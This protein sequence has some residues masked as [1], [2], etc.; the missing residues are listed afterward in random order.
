MMNIKQ[1]R[2]DSFGPYENWMFQSGPNGVQLVYGANESGKTSLLEGM[3]ALLFG[4]KHKKYGYVNG[5][6]ELDKDGIAYHLGRQNKNLDF[7]SPGG[8]NLKDEPNQ[9]WWHG[10]DKKT[11]NRIFGLTLDDLQGVDVLNEVDVRARFFGAEGGE[12]LGNVVKT[13]EM[14]ANDLLV[15]SASGK[16]RINVLI[17]QLQEN[18]A[19]LSA[20]SAHE[21]QYVEL[22]QAL[23]ASEDTEAEIQN[24]IKEWQDYREGVEMVLRAW[25][26]YRR[27]EEA[28]QHMQR[29]T[30]PETL[31]RDAFLGIDEGL[32]EARQ[33]MQMW[34]DK[35][36]A[37]KPENF[38]PNSPFTMYGQDIEDLIQQGAQWEQLRRECEEGDAYIAKVKEQLDFSRGLQSAWRKDESVPTDVNWFE[39][40]RL[41]KR[42]R[43]AKDQLLY[44][45]GQDPALQV[46]AK[47]SE[48]EAVVKDSSVES[49]KTGVVNNWAHQEL[50]A[51][52]ADI[53]DLEAQIGEE[54][55]TR[56]A[57]LPVW[58]QR[59]GGIGAVVGVLL[60]LAGL[61]ALESAL[62][63]VGGIVLLILGLGLFWYGWRLRHIDNADLSRWMRELDR[64]Q[65]R[66]AYLE[67]QL[68]IPLPKESSNVPNLETAAIEQRYNEEG[69]Q[70]QANYDK[71]LAEWQAWIPEGAAKSLNEDDFFSMKHEYDQYYEQLRTIEGYEKRL[72]EHKESLRVIEDQAVT[73]W[74]NL[75]IEAPVS[76]TELKRI[77][78]QYKNFQQQMI[79][80]EQKESQRKSYRME[81][82]NWHRKE[83]EL[84]LEQKALLEKSGLSG[85][86]EYRQKLIDEDQYKQWA[87][88]YKQ[89]QVQLELLT[90]E[91]E[92]KDLFYRRLREG[93]KDNWNDEL[94]HADQELGARKDA[95]ANL[96]E[97]RGQIVEAMRALGSDQ[98]QREAIQQR[99][100]LESELESALEDWA[101]QVVIG[102]CMERAQQSYEEESQPKML[103]LASQY[104]NRLTNGTY[105]LDMWGL[106][107][108]LALLNERG[109]RLPIS[110]WSS[111]LADQV[112]LALRLALAKVF[113]Y[114]VD[115]LPIILDDILVRFDENRQKGA[116]ELLAELG[117]QQQIWLFTCQQQVYYMGQ[118]I[119]GIDTH[120]LQRA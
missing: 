60:S 79:R 52:I 89:S 103:E 93:N 27:S 23:R 20:L 82:D 44:W 80:W 66:K 21:E 29:F 100:E 38:D 67:T 77:Y 4:G 85:A 90:P 110:R 49:D 102:H 61:I 81:Y 43:T 99:K 50:E 118:A 62:Y 111:G 28:R 117:Q 119:S 76:P 32:R 86:N 37:L 24:Q 68:D 101:T 59:I 72:E 84:L 13:I 53:A 97:K 48:S 51:V 2:L 83:K 108:G 57:A 63:S 47:S 96:Y 98:E 6:L 34:L 33:S 3:R 116:L 22:Q 8:P 88:I 10:L 58:L 107:D 109:D 104:I 120:I 55:S 39:G 31:N 12:Q 45:Q 71:A 54:G 36:E 17:E 74:Y 26:T 78:N 7:Y 41:S 5:S 105:T 75:G 115:A 114:Q 64:L 25:D 106:Q 40:E 14:S 92:N 73:L 15:A 30:P 11:Y 9:L 113:S 42:L 35:E 56:K 18:K 91:G 65:Q 69:K 70:L 95:M 87:T 46:E 94:V 19:R 112:Y 1:I 16:R